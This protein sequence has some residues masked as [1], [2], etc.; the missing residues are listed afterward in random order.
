MV[1][2]RLTEQRTRC[3]LVSGVEDER[4]EIVQ[5]AEIGRHA[6]KQFEIVT[7]RLFEPALLSEQTGALITSPDRVRVPLQ[8][9]IKLLNAQAGGEPHRMLVHG[10]QIPLS[11]CRESIARP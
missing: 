3:I 10:V 6:P 2:Y 7:L 4:A 9:P 11:R 8:R 5:R 1:T